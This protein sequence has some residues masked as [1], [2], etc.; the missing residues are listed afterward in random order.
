M[1]KKI[2][3]IGSTGF[4]G[5]NTL[6]YFC[7]TKKYSVYALTRKKQN[8]PKNIKQINSNLYNFNKLFSDINKI[9]FNIVINLALY[10]DHEVDFEK[11]YWEIQIFPW[12]PLDS[13][14][15][16]LDFLKI[17]LMRFYWFI[18]FFKPTI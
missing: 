11:G 7:K 9:K 10:V 18:F 8:Y 4:L 12:G 15:L 5:S 14:G 2:L 3:I 17:S 6:N 1:K 16:P 13:L